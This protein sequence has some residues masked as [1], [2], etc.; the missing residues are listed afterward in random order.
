MIILNLIKLGPVS[1]IQMKINYT[2]IASVVISLKRIIINGLN[3]QEKVILSQRYQEN[4]GE[5]K[6]QKVIK[7]YNLIQN[8]QQEL[9][10]R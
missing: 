2:D 10:K 6:T 3:A 9:S 7:N 1:G 5:L 4:E 8:E